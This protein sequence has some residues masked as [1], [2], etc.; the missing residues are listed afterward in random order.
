M[1]ICC[2]CCVMVFVCLRQMGAVVAASSDGGGAGA[3]QTELVT[4]D[5]Q[6]HI[7][8]SNQYA[9]TTHP[10]KQVTINATCTVYVTTT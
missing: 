7:T 6:T 5:S 4:P 10:V 2:D 1:G 9:L 3:R 8:S